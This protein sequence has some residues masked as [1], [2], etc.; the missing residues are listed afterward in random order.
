MSK[1]PEKFELGVVQSLGPYSEADAERA[2]DIAVAGLRL[3]GYWPGGILA[4][5]ESLDHTNSAVRG[6]AA[7]RLGWRKSQEAVDRLLELLPFA[8]DDSCSILDALGMI[9]DERAIP[10]L[11]EYA[12]RKLLSRRRSAAEAILQIGNEEAWKEVQQRAVE[13]LPSTV[14]VRFEGGAAP[15]IVTLVDE[16]ERLN[17]NH[18]A[19]AL[20]TL[21]ELATPETVAA[22]RE[23]LQGIAFPEA[24]TWRA[25]KSIFKRAML[26][27]DHAT[28]GWLAW[29][30]EERGR[31]TKGKTAK[32]RSGYDGVER[33][34]PIFSRTTQSYLRLR[35]WRY[36]QDL[37]RYRPDRYA[38][39]AAELI[40]HYFPQQ[41]PDAN[42]MRWYLLHQVL[43]GKSTRFTLD[44]WQLR[45][46]PRSG[47]P[48][49]PAPTNE[50]R[51]ES[52]PELW[53]DQPKAYL[54]LLQAAQLPLVHEFAITRIN[55]EHPLLIREATH[56][57]IILMLNAPY[58]RT[59]EL[60]LTELA[61]RFDRNNPNWDLIRQL[62]WNDHSSS[63]KLGVQWLELTRNDWVTEANLI[64]DF[65]RASQF[66]IRNQIV[67]MVI[68]P[69]TTRPE[70][71]Q[72]LAEK[73]APLLQNE[74]TQLD[75]YAGHFSVAQRS[76]IAE[77]NSLVSANALIRLVARGADVV[78]ELAGEL[79]GHR[80][81]ALSLLGIERL[82][83]LAQH[84]IASVRRAGH[85]L[86]RA[87]LPGLRDDPSLL[88][89]L[90]E[91]EWDDTREIAFEL[92]RHHIDMQSLG[93]DGLMGLLD[94][95]RTDVQ[96]LGKDL[97]QIH[98]GELPGEEIVRRLVEHPHKNMR[99]FA[100]EL[101]KQFLP[102]TRESLGQL[103]TFCRSALFDVWPDR[104]VKHLVIEFL[105]NRGRE[106]REQADEAVA[107]LGDVVR[108][109]GREDFE[110]AVAALVRIKLVYPDVATTVDVLAE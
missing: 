63:Q 100:L 86:L 5:L 80:P 14:R 101:A 33:S 90:V 18:R 10:V 12:S 13:R 82:A 4:L 44:S 28:F 19:L 58:E 108:V 39:A 60:A 102:K 93:I 96:D 106:D 35:S 47:W 55:S 36:L 107:I 87:A 109:E 85:A 89:V 30:V 66:E 22:A 40:I 20:D 9:G 49:A 74:L 8:V 72:Q 73:I 17:V 6:R 37:A 99:G 15:D 54:R 67:E 29:A 64:F 70:T 94:S 27:H 52:Y 2:F 92:L 46:R 51:E 62:V 65:L 31:T 78:K 42:T 61:R 16:V 68:L 91:S 3:E 88:F 41:V 105:G 32:V 76:L 77:M 97:V 7:L 38:H 104:K 48:G 26:R 43:Y 103:K 71:R 81:E 57:D 83:A 34:T 98:I 59:L 25:I 84:E 21:Y 95:N 23:V 24:F 53:D 11:R 45:F 69:L 50:T 75:Q 79:L 56:E 110:L 1:G